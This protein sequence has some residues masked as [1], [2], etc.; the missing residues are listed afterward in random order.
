MRIYIVRHGKA[1]EQ[2]EARSEFPRPE[3]YPSDWDRPLTRRGMAQATYLGAQVRDGERRINV[4]L[5]SRY[6]RAIQ[7][8]RLIAA[9]IGAEVR[10]V[11]ELEVDHSVSEAM[12]LLDEY[13]GSRAIMLVGHN[14]QLGELLSVLSSGLSAQELVL[15]TGELVALEMRASSGVGAARVVSRIRMDEDHELSR[16]KEMEKKGKGHERGRGVA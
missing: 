7:T 12:R 9:E 5:S 8:A 6:P 2:P 16:E 3:G 4:I 11:S 14:P 13:R 10:L 1:T 15:K